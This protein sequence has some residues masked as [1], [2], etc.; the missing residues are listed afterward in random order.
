MWKN[1]IK[2]HLKEHQNNLSRA[3]KSLSKDK[4]CLIHHNENVKKYLSAELETLAQQTSDY[5]EPDKLEEYHELLWVYADIFSN[6]IHNP[7]D[8][9]YHDLKSLIK[10]KDINVLQGDKDSSI[11]IM[12]S[13]KFYEKLETM[14]NE[15]IKNGISRLPINFK[16]YKDYK[17]MRPVSD[18]PAWF[19]VSTKTRKFDNINDV[20]LDQL[21]FQPIMDQMGTYTYNA[22]Q[23]ISNYV[24]PLCIN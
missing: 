22:A 2:F 21:K 11:I 5:V 19:Y 16:D 1:T 24:K 23:V 15:V 20:N 14:V 8:Y 17:K 4:Y 13:K 7:K 10:N 6:N 18:R 9:T 3:I 12:D